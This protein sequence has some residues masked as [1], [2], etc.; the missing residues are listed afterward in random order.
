MVYTVLITNICSMLIRIFEEKQNEM[1][2]GRVVS[3]YS[4]KMTAEKEAEK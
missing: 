4:A 3:K 2:T 1:I